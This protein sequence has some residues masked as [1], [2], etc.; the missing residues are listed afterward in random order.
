MRG[1]QSLV[2]LRRIPLPRTPV[3]KSKGKGRGLTLRPFGDGSRIM[4]GPRKPSRK[5]GKGQTGSIA[6]SESQ[7]PKTRLILGDENR[8][9]VRP[10]G[11]TLGFDCGIPLKET[12][13]RDLY[14]FQVG[15]G[16]VS[17]NTLQ[18]C[19]VHSHLDSVDAAQE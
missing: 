16:V 18:I 6:S 19:L 7:V 17:S 10:Y 9:R 11:A 12:R 15:L 8:G 2:Q 5:A 4:L 14:I 3:N 13:H 1:L